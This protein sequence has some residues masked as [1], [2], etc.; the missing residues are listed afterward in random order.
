MLH[1]ITLENAEA[2]DA[3]VAAYPKSPVMQTSLWGKVKK[4]WRQPALRA[5]RPAV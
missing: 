2:L 4:D 5:M 3:Y 1:Y